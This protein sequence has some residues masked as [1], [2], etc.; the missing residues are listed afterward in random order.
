LNVR[1]ALLGLFV[2]LTLVFASTT[3]YESITRT[4][5]VSTTTSTVAST[6]PSA[7]NEVANSYEEHLLLLEGQWPFPFLTG[8]SPNAT[9]EWKGGA[10]RWDGNYTGSRL[11]NVTLG[12]PLWNQQ[13]LLVYC[14]NQTI[15]TKDGYWIVNSSFDFAGNN[16]GGPGVYAPPFVGAFWGTVA[17][18]DSYAYIDKMWL[19]VN[20]T[21]TFQSVG[22]GGYPAHCTSDVGLF[23]L[24]TGPG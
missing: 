13:Y 5:I 22:Q 4:T 17:A 16:T 12:G 7:Y 15:A 18:Q 6:I 1:T 20:E 3:L 2:M 11:G 21:W 10:G 14:E 24:Q 23:P 19:I 9:I 8:Y